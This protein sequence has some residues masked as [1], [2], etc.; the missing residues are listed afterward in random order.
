MSLCKSKRRNG[1][2]DKRL[3]VFRYKRT[4]SVVNQQSRGD[5]AHGI[6]QDAVHPIGG[7]VVASEAEL[8]EDGTNIRSWKGNDS[9]GL[10]D[11]RHARYLGTHVRNI[12]GRK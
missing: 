12:D 10:A 3:G 5:K 4:E 7:R 11:L 2:D 9:R 8:S 1:S 6:R